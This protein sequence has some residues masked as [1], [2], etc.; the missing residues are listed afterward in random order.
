MT[1]GIY[2]TAVENQFRQSW[3]H[4]TVC[5]EVKAIYKIV[6]T[7]ASLSQY[8]QYLYEWFPVISNLPLTY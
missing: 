2:Q 6:G 8:E 3:R 1:A 7:E 5:P 4:N